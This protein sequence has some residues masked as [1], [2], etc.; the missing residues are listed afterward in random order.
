MNKIKL[1]ILAVSIMTFYSV[2]T[3]A[4]DGEKKEQTVEKINENLSV[5]NYDNFANSL[6]KSNYRNEAAT[7]SVQE[8]LLD[9]QISVKSKI[10]E[11]KR[12]DFLLELPIEAHV[13][14]SKFKN[15]LEEK[16]TG[17]QI[18]EESMDL[19]NFVP[20]TYEIDQLIFSEREK[21]EDEASDNAKSDNP[22]SN[23]NNAGGQRSQE[24][25]S[26][27]ASEEMG[28]DGVLNIGGYESIEIEP[29]EESETSDGSNQE[30]EIGLTDAELDALGITR[31]EYESWV[32]EPMA[33]G[34]E[35]EAE[36]DPEENQEEPE[37]V[38]PEEFL[39]VKN[40]SVSKI[41]IFGNN[42]KADISM[43]LYIGDGITGED[44]RRSYSNVE[45]GEI[46]SFDD[47]K[48]RV[49]RIDKTEIEIK[50][51]GTDKKYVATTTYS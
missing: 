17:Y 34:S 21:R 3:I 27:Q 26:Q 2:P 16:P 22:N 48:I 9:R 28:F 23:G 19:K 43:E 46:I 33:G 41:I 45:E 20:P 18:T 5:S 15:V 38:E 37:E 14:T 44:T 12:L 13:D 42:K 7:L 49:V 47:Y 6:Q 35:E 29:T 36:Y 50:I 24:D 40:F 39:E 32:S 10:L 25:T 51:E 11:N 4:Q 31:E 8:N 1:S 30:E